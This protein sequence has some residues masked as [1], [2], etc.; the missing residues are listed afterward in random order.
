MGDARLGEVV[1][2]MMPSQLNDAYLARL[3]AG[4]VRFWPHK[5]EKM[6]TIP[7]TDGSH[8]IL[9]CGQAARVNCDRN[10]AKAW[11]R[12]IRRTRGSADDNE[13][14]EYLADSELGYA[15]ANPGTSEGEDCKPESATEFPNKW[16]VRECE[17]CAMSAPE[18]WL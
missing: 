13:D 5:D 2:P 12:S 1:T 16:C 7:L 4:C 3:S 6:K 17:R 8:L 15:P 14:G 10:C 11:G 18:K 9:F